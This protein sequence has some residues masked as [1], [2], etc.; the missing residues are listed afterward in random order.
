MPAHVNETSDS[1]DNLG[2]ILSAV[3]LVGGVILAINFAVVPDEGT[4]VF[5]LVAIAVA[6]GIVFIIRQKRARN[7]LYD[8]HIVARR[9]FWVAAVVG[10]I[11]FGSLMAAMF[12]GQQERA[13]L[14]HARSGRRPSSP[15]R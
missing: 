14:R 12:I 8:L 13:R 3:L 11:V 7:P 6:A 2:G 5:G 9:I 4:L 1:V 15:P 10:I